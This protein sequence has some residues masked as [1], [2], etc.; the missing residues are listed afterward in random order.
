M[1]P[2]L[3]GDFL[4]EVLHLEKERSDRSKKTQHEKFAPLQDVARDD[5]GKSS[6]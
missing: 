6:L 1:M 5:L 3:S 2:E 4:D